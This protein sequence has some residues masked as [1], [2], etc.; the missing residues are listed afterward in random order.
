MLGS[1]GL[2]GLR[3]TGEVSPDSTEPTPENDL[4]F[5]G[6]KVKSKDGAGGGGDHDEANVLAPREPM[7]TVE[8]SSNRKGREPKDIEGSKL[9]FMAVYT[10]IHS[11]SSLIQS[12]LMMRWKVRRIVAAFQER[13]NPELCYRLG[14][15]SYDLTI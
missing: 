3:S 15:K 2:L 7:V 1:T 10:V 4:G 12:T 14:F 8:T 6:A 9:E 5:V 11:S 13:L